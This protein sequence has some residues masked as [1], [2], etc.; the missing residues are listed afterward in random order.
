MASEQSLLQLLQSRSIV[1]CDTMDVEVA[2]SL[3][4]FVDCTS[5][6]A[7]AYFELLKPVHK[8]RIE[9]VIRMAQI[10]TASLTISTTELAVEMA[11]VSLQLEISRHITGLVHVQTNPYYAYDSHKTVDNARRIVKLFQILDPNFDRTRVC[12]KIP[13]TWEGL[14]A[15]RILKDMDIK[16]LATT[17]FTIEQASLAGEV[18]CH[19]IA[20]YVNELKV[21][22][23]ASFIDNNKAQKLCITAQHLYQTNDMKTQVLPASLTS[24][25]EIMELAGVDHITIAPGLL[26]QLADT[27]ASSNTT[28]SLFDAKVSAEPVPKFVSFA[29]DE[30]KY[31]MAFTRSNGGNGEGEKKLVQ[32][33]NIFCDMQDKLEDIMGQLLKNGDSETQATISEAN[34]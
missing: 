19:Y 25:A 21:H 31:R 32:A 22:F 26:Q 34:H 20:P 30:S 24:V 14:Q 2:K 7:I 29:N 16:T 5:N 27:S 12:V 8:A 15:C 23:D 18:G 1:D 28:V 17:L 3:G 11:M 6:Q 9:K 13:S 10:P 33:I 4:P